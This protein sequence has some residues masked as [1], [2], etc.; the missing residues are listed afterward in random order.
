M[1]GYPYRSSLT[2]LLFLLVTQVVFAQK[3]AFLKDYAERWETSRQYMLTV[4]EAMPESEYG[5]KPT[6][7]EMTFAEQLMHIAWVIDWHA[8]SK[9]DGQ[10]YR[11]RLNDFKVEGRTKKEM[12]E[13]VNREFNRAAELVRSLDPA[14]LDQ[15]G[16]YAKFTR[17]RR[18]FLLLMTDHVTHHR[19]QMLVYLR[20]KG[21]VPPKYIEFQ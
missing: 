16:S 1:T 5:F 9:A 19:A 11:P 20:L 8:F 2:C 10:E 13:M 17:T 6:P 14:R 15:T 4:A 7:E 18:Q 3:D 12:I 21:I